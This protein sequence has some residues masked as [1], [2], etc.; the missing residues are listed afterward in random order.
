MRL[1]GCFHCIGLHACLHLSPGAGDIF[2]SKT[3]HRAGTGAPHVWRIVVNIKASVYVFVFLFPSLCYIAKALR[4]NWYMS[5]FFLLFTGKYA[6]HNTICFCILARSTLSGPEELYRFIVC[7][8]CIGLFISFFSPK[9]K[10]KHLILATIFILIELKN[11][12]LQ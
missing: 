1:R 10:K 2:K 12:L 3:S 8:V 9:G 4:Y 11:R 6:L 7:C 5:F